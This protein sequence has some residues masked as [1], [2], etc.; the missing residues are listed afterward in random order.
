MFQPTLEMG[1]KVFK[2]FF[3]HNYKVSKTLKTVYQKTPVLV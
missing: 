3:Y 1:T 2:K